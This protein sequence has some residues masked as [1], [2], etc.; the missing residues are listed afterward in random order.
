MSLRNK[1]NSL[2][3]KCKDLKIRSDDVFVKTSTWYFDENGIIPNSG[4]TMR[5]PK[6]Q[7]GQYGMFLTH[8]PMSKEE[9]LEFV[10][11]RQGFDIKKIVMKVKS[12]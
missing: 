11:N 6:E 7:A 5:V 4:Q 9:W 1:L 3:R 8:K 12:G 10:K 2:E